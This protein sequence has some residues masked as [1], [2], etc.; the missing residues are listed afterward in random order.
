MPTIQVKNTLLHL[1]GQNLTLAS[2][3]RAHS[4]APGLHLSPAPAKEAVGRLTASPQLTQEGMAQ[5]DM[6]LPRTHKL[7]LDKGSENH[8]SRRPL[9]LAPLDLSEELRQ[10]QKQKLKCGH[11]AVDKPKVKT[12]VTQSCEKTSTIDVRKPSK[13]PVIKGMEDVVCQGTQA[14]L[15]PKLTP[16][17]PH[18]KARSK[19]S[20]GPNLTNQDN[21]GQRRLRLA[22]VQSQEDD[23]A[24]CNVSTT[25]VALSSNEDRLAKG[26]QS[27]GQ[28]QDRALRGNP[29]SGQGINELPVV[30]RGKPCVKKRSGEDRPEQVRNMHCGGWSRRT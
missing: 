30:P 9:K 5:L 21:A 3:N 15:L 17:S 10:A 14:P 1:N 8:P 11:S 26:V 19:V 12:S 18:I 23:E 2:K 25:V 29:Q 20:K 4:Q 6:L 28:L 16:N 27:R 24:K 22:R 13:P 7:V